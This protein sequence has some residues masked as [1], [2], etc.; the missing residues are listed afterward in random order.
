MNIGDV[1][2]GPRHGRRYRV[3]RFEK[4]GLN[5]VVLWNETFKQEDKAISRLTVPENGWTKVVVS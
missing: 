3:L 5:D 2:I 1:Y 4:N